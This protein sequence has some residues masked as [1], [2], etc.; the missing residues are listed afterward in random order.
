MPALRKFIKNAIVRIRRYDD[1]RDRN[2]T[3]LK[4]LKIIE[5]EKGK[6][7]LEN[8]KLCNKYA[9]DILGSKNY[10]PWLYAYTA[11]KG[12]FKEGWIPDNY[13]GQHVLPNLN[14]NYG[15]LCNTKAA[16]DSLIKITNSIDKCYY[17]NNLFLDKKHNVLKEDTIKNFIF[18]DEDK[19]VYKLESSQRGKGIFFFN[20]S[21]FNIDTIKKLGNGVF[22]T[23]I[24]QH[25][26]FSNFTKNS[27]ATIRLISA[28]KD[29]GDIAI[30]GGYLR[31]GR[32]ND[33]H[34]ISSSAIR[35]PIDVKKGILDSSAYFPNWK[36]TNK[37]PDNNYYFAQKELPEY[38]KCV[39]EIKRMH[40]NVPFIRCIGWDLII[41]NKNNL[42][43]IEVNG[44]HPGIK[45]IET[46]QGPCFKDL[47]W[48]KFNDLKN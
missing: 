37:L 3:A 2:N 44:S 42:V 6:L 48:E 32:K 40:S 38:T 11:F 4:F 39:S 30:C 41:D 33:T 29:D 1:D 7:S 24:K 12:K 19:I 9:K 13:Y 22:Q 46:V 16:I 14:G 20:K 43:V 10:A 28:C 21:N 45:F 5:Q 18:K 34:V 17:V 26:F 23:Y 35:I 27:V 8:K 15:Q 25:S 31:F 36:S 47:G